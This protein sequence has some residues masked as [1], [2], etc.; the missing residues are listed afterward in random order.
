MAKP[1]LNVDKMELASVIEMI[2]KDGPLTNRFLLHEAVANTEWAKNHPN[3]AVTPSV[4]F[5]R[6]DEFGIEPKTPKG[7]RGRPPANG[8]QTNTQTNTQTANREIVVRIPKTKSEKLSSPA[9]QS[10]FDR[11]SELAPTSFQKT[12]ERARGGSMAAA[13]RLKCA[14]CVCFEE[15]AKNVR[16]CVASD[17]PIWPFRPYQVSIGG[18]PVEDEDIDIGISDD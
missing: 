9:A 4:V 13:V 6:I 2:E 5:L 16:G 17:C 12:I 14:Q 8:Y 10:V 11:L 7:R 15:V 1:K 18:R 3:K